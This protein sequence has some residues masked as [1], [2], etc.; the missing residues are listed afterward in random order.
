MGLMLTASYRLPGSPGEPPQKKLRVSGS[1]L[2]GL[3]PAVSQQ[4]KNALHDIVGAEIHSL[5]SED[6]DACIAYN[7]LPGD[8]VD[9]L[10]T[11]E[12]LAELRR[13]GGTLSPAFKAQLA[14]STRGY[15]RMLSRYQVRLLF[16]L[17]STGPFVLTYLLPTIGTARYPKWI[18]PTRPGRDTSSRASFA[19]G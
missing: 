12:V 8:V 5:S 16:S 18:I 15:L 19:A 9:R 3:H 13:H 4:V 6:T 7:R 14:N 1:F 17:R 2:D 10:A 11:S